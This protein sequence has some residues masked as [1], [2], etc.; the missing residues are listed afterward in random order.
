MGVLCNGCF[1]G[2]GERVAK[3]GQVQYREGHIGDA[4]WGTTWYFRGWR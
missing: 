4:V 3:R 2:P 1:C